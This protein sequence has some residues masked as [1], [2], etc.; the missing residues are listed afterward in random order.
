MIPQ[1]INLIVDIAME[2]N[3]ETSRRLRRG[4]DRRQSVHRNGNF[5]KLSKSHTFKRA[6]VPNTVRPSLVLPAQ[7]VKFPKFT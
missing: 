1:W 6:S 2:K 3:V 4:N 7:I 5:V